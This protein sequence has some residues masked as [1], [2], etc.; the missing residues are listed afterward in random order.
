MQ[1]LSQRN[2]NNHYHANSGGLNT[3]EDGD[4]DFTFNTNDMTKTIDELLNQV[5]KRNRFKNKQSA[6]VVSD[7]MQQDLMNSDKKIDEEKIDGSGGRMSDVVSGN[8]QD[9]EGE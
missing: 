1:T 9:I 6:H 5:M 7:E 4:D 3:E 2:S 8:F